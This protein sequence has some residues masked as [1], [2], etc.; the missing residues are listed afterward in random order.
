MTIATRLRA[1]PLPLV[2]MLASALA[3]CVTPPP[4]PD[5]RA[6]SRA[7]PVPSGLV[8]FRLDDN[9]VFL[10]MTL[11]AA[12]GRERSALALMNMG[13]AGPALSNALYRD[14]GVGEGRPLRMRVGRTE[15]VIDP[16]TVQPESE[17]LGFP[18][19]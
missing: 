9:R 2:L 3:G 12:D 13:F 14:L 5:M 7:M 15:I 16:R 4:T 19:A 10:P 11:V 8:S 6:M 18:I 17:V 1:R